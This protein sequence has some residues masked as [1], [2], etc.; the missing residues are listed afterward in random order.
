MLRYMMLTY[1][2]LIYVENMCYFPHCHMLGT[3]EH[4]VHVFKYYV[5]AFDVAMTNVGEFSSH[6]LVKYQR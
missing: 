3:N 1:V 2:L 4:S 6:K 5:I